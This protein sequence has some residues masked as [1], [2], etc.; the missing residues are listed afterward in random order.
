MP[1]EREGPA[2]RNLFGEVVQQ[3]KPTQDRAAGETLPSGIHPGTPFSQVGAVFEE[4]LPPGGVRAAKKFLP[5]SE[6]RRR[7]VAEVTRN[8]DGLTYGQVLKAYNDC[9][10]GLA[11]ARGRIAPEDTLLPTEVLIE[12]MRRTLDALERHLPVDALERHLP[13]DC[14]IE[15]RQGENV[16]ITGPE[17]VASYLRPTIAHLPQEQ[18]RVLWLDTRNQVIGQHM[19][20]QGTGNAAPVRAADVFRPA[21]AAGATAIIIAHNHPSGDPTPSHED[22]NITKLLR[23]AG[24]ELGIELLDHVVVGRTASGREYA[25]IEEIVPSGQRGTPYHE[26]AQ[27]PTPFDPAATRGAEDRAAEYHPRRPGREAAPQGTGKLL[28]KPDVSQGSVKPL[29]AA[30]EAGIVQAG[31]AGK[32]ARPRAAAPLGNRRVNPAPRLTPAGNRAQADPPAAR[33][34]LGR[35]GRR[36]HG[37]R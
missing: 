4:D 24:N 31:K 36:R 34:P 29:C 18:L 27:P 19:A 20:H 26:T 1:T 14:R 9:V 12:R 25:S 10:T 33:H 7:C 17:D 5:R 15:H 28:E 35:L 11:A 6:D 32:Q 3:E 37:V 30:A 21:M 2:Q 8:A 23:K 16:R 13:V 22:I